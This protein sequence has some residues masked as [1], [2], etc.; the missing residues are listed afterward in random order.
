MSM[1]QVIETNQEK[2]KGVPE[3]LAQSIKEAKTNPAMEGGEDTAK[4]P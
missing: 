2:E 4:R 1:N 3:P